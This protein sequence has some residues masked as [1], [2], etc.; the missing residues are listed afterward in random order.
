MGEVGHANAPDLLLPGA[1]RGAQFHAGGQALRRLSTLAD[2]RHYLAGA[3]VGRSIKTT[4]VRRGGS[5]RM[6]DRWLDPTGRGPVTVPTR[7]S[8]L[9]KGRRGANAFPGFVLRQ[10]KRGVN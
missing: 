4:R 9:A 1:L 3:G 6:F 5:V 8:W 2:Q 7:G 10:S